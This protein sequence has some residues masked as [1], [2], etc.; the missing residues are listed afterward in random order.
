MLGRALKSLAVEPTLSRS[1]V[2]DPQHLSE[3]DVFVLLCRPVP[4][5]G[6]S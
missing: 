1:L 3:G 5:G 2:P 6:A 4:E